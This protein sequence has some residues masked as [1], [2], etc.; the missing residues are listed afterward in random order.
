MQKNFSLLFFGKR[1]R[2]NPNEV[3]IFVRITV[4]GV[5]TEFSS[6]RDYP[7]EQWNAQASKRIGN[8]NEVKSFNMYL[9][10]IRVN[11]YEAYRQLILTT[12][13]SQPKHFET[14]FRENEN[15]PECSWKSFKSTT[16]E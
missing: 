7:I 13:Q 12:K 16:T 10:T 3:F 9:D 6:S 11:V 4:D 15:G 2:S 8:S 1:K 14:K 5:R